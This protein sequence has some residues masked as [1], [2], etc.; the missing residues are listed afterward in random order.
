MGLSLKKLL[1][2]LAAISI[3]ATGSAATG[4]PQNRELAFE[5]SSIGDR[6][7]EDLRRCLAT[8]DALDVY[9]LID[10]SGSLFDRGTRPG[11]DPDFKRSEILGESL[12]QL[13]N[14]ASE[15][16][17]SKVVSWNAG[18]FSDEFFPASDTWFD[19]EPSSVEEDVEMLDVAI[20]GNVGGATDWL[21]GVQGA[22]REL[23]S[24][25][26]VSRG[27]QVLI[28]LTDGGL[29]VQ[30]DD[31]LSF[32]AMNS[33]C[34]VAVVPEGGTP[35]FG[36]GPLYEL[37]QSGVVVFGVLLDVVG[38]GISELYSDRKSWLQPLVEG[39]GRADLQGG[40]KTINCGD[41]TG[42]IPQNHA[43]GAFIRAQQL[44]DLA[45]QFLRLSGLIQG[46]S[47]GSLA[48][49]G[50]F[51]I[52]P[53]VARVEL[54]SLAEPGQLTLTDPTGNILSFG[55]P[56]IEVVQS[57]GALKVA[58][59]VDSKADFGKWKLA[60]VEP[61]SVV[62]IA[63]SAL[64][65]NP[66]VS[67]ALISGQ[68]SEVLVAAEV[69]DPALFSVSDYS[70]QIEAF[71]Q[72]ENGNFVSIGKSL[73]SELANG[74]WRLEITPEANATQVNLRFEATGISTTAGGTRLS[75]IASE[76][77]LVVS[78][79]ANF[80]TFGP[81]PIDL[82][83]LQGRL[84]PATEFLTIYAPASGEVG[85]FCYGDNPNFVV[86]SDAIDRAATWNL[87]ISPAAASSLVAGCLEIRPGSTTQVQ[88]SLR[89]SE[90]A[91][92]QVTGFVDFTLRDSAGAELQVRAPVTLET[93][94]IINPLVLALLQILLVLLGVI[95]PLV[96]IYLVNRFSS[97][98]EHGNELLKAVL[99]VAVNL[100][101]GEIKSSS[102]LDLKSS[103]VGLDHFKFQPP[104]PDSREIEVSGLGTAKAKVSANPLVAP[105][106]EIEAKPESSVFTGKQNQKNGRRFV[107]GVAAEFSGQLS[108]TWGLSV[109]HSALRGAS[110][111]TEDLPATLVVFA[112]NAGGVSPNFQERMIGVLND[113]KVSGSILSA[114]EGLDALEKKKV[115]KKDSKDAGPKSG[116]NVPRGPSA[117]SAPR[118][119]AP[120]TT[121]H[122]APSLRPA[123]PGTPG[124]AGPSRPQTGPGGPS[125]PKPPSLS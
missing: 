70:F 4:L 31:S 121:G 12:R 112:R 94:R 50:S 113:A 125:L 122:P 60:G 65:V 46:G 109:S 8:N 28:F 49:D 62:L 25:K 97:K 3:F 58:I 9:Y 76:Q 72:T 79:P 100:K 115:S 63:Y 110:P 88:L 80:P 117:P 119:G 114:K 73:S 33:L 74:I 86:Q 116:N 29:N 56:G 30:D 87:Q 21:K 123:T 96:T 69:S 85:Y 47:L 51:D 103:Q 6:A 77:S 41:G 16:G 91:N 20:K 111:S 107:S 14:L 118:L 59:Q 53:G 13:S 11:T 120:A 48:S 45:V 37:R 43:S 84:N 26:K 19:L 90:T 67:N 95:L 124:Q 52:N 61:A 38:P 106:F 68:A 83:T 102:N 99:P 81:I 42:V 27:C 22:Q 93:Q 24:Q 89:N 44:G 15:T 5:L 55:A 78:L 82:G 39:T 7:V 2:L 34:G 98:V 108:K 17:G 1:A 64:S 18:F 71:S 36:L 75:S 23:A 104:K 54:L 40:P 92:S 66:E 105:W 101:T 32:L 35:Q 10:R 57:A